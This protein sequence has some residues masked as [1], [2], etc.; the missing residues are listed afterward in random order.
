MEWEKEEMKW[1]ELNCLKGR[2]WE[3][4]YFSICSLYICGNV[5]IKCMVIIIENG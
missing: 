3:T 5:G 4:N 1:S 2:D